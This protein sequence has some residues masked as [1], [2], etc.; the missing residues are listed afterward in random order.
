MQTMEP[1]IRELTF[2]ERF[3]KIWDLEG[4]LRDNIIQ[5][6]NMIEKDT[7]SAQVNQALNILKEEKETI[8]ISSD[9]IESEKSF[10]IK[11]EKARQ[12][13]ADVSDILRSVNSFK[14]AIPAFCDILMMYAY[15]E[16]YFTQNEKYH[17]CK[18]DTVIVRRCDVKAGEN[19]QMDKFNQGT[20]I[21][22]GQK[23]YDSQYIWGQ[24]VGWFKQTVDKPNAS[25][26][27][28][29][30]GTLSIPDVHSFIISDDKLKF[31]DDKKEKP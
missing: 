27:A 31:E 13:I 28:D 8:T 5:V 15:T 7:W 25:L 12:K 2:E 29:R 20:Q 23:E 18:S 1:P 11:Y 22:S 17:R 26:S 3:T 30:R 9:T 16:T 10:K 6:I 4:C 14:V 21:Y 24:L 19:A